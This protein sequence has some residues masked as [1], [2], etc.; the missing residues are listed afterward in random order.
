MCHNSTGPNWVSVTVT[1]FVQTSKYSTWFW[2]FF[3]WIQF[4]FKRH[5]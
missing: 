4:S 3:T 1:R 5:K 2:H